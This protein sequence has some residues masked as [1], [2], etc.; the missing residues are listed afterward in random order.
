MVRFDW[1]EVSEPGDENYTEIWGSNIANNTEDT[2]V[3]KT[4]QNQDYWR[5]N[6]CNVTLTQDSE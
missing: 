1:E 3:N 5:E 4:Q 6:W 2:E